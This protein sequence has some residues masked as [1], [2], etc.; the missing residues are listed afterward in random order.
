MGIERILDIFMDYVGT[1][2][3]ESTEKSMSQ[4]V[5]QKMQEDYINS[6]QKELLKTYGDEVFYNDLCN[7]MFTNHTLERIIKRA[8]D[9]ELYDKMTDTE[10]IERMLVGINTQAH[11]R[12]KEILLKILETS[13]QRMNK[14]DDLNAIKLKNIIKNNSDEINIALRTVLDN[15]KKILNNQLKEQ[16]VSRP[17]KVSK[18]ESLEALDISFGCKNAVQHFLGRDTEI[19]DIFKIMQDVQKST[20]VLRLWIWGMGG[21]GKTQLCRKAYEIAK[22]KY[23]YIGW[24]TY[25][26]NMKD[27][28]V[29]GISTLKRTADIDN[30]YCEALKYLNTLGKQA[31]IFIDNY[32]SLNDS[33]QDIEKLQCNVVVTSRNKNPDSFVEYKLGHLSF[34]KCKELFCKFY[35]IENNI[36]MNE[37]IHRTGYLVLA[38]ELVAK[39]GQKLGI[40]LAEYYKKLEEKGFDIRTVIESNWDNM[41]EKV[42]TELSKHFCI[43]FDLS[44]FTRNS[45]AMYVL[46]NM[47]VFPYLGTPKDK[48]IEW[49]ELDIE[50]NVLYD[51]ADSGWLERTKEFD[52]IMHPIIAYTVKHTNPPLIKDCAALINALSEIITVNA[53]ENYLKAITY[54]P[55]AQSVG[56]FY[57]MRYEDIQ[58]YKMGVFYCRLAEF[59][60]NIGEYMYALK[61][62]NSA[63]KILEN[64]IREKKEKGRLANLLYNILAEICLDMRD[65]DIECRDWAIKAIESDREYREFLDNISVSTSFHNL[66]CAYIQLNENDLAFKNQIIAVEYREKI[67]DKTNPLLL[68][69]YRNLAMIYR[70]KKDVENA[71][72]YQKQVIETLE[73]IHKGE[74]HPDLPVAYNIYSFILRDRGELEQ[75]I[76]YQK[77]STEIREAVNKNDPKLAINY[78]N[79]GI[80]YMNMK[81]Y[82]E[83]KKWQVKSLQTDLKNKR[84]HHP[85][86]VTDFFNYGKI[87]AENKE[88]QRAIKS[89]EISRKIDVVIGGKNLNEIDTL[90][91][92]IRLEIEN[93][94]KKC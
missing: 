13:Y 74:N 7:V 85:D 4:K 59:Y 66:A 71:Y 10:F 24:I 58:E 21:M 1:E 36:I 63:Y 25:Q 73:E 34:S 2:I 53:G 37:I 26:N 81:K 50:N 87:L 45:E 11:N 41:G 43:V 68:N 8:Y 49:L 90:I 84:W 42:N 56:E 57:V 40:T 44:G 72:Y 55:Y 38:V 17:D 32:D 64:N 93:S 91:S 94:L 52:Y 69:S 23:A 83:A 29:N 3:L 20:G 62:A 78:N 22:R 51:L 88:Y 27:S 79:L 33:I 75:A 54:L 9:R 67:L 5:Y 76:E 60:R 19:K 92:D 12:I 70:R 35:T 77:K 39:T 82:D 18:I 47:S 15:T 46:K 80:F 14:M 6:L 16:E 28:I 89:L 65:K 31:I 61:W 48:I 30:D 86:V